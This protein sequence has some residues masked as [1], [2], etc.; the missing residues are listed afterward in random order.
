MIRQH[1][2]QFLSNRINV[3]AFSQH[4]YQQRLGAKIFN[5]KALFPFPSL[6]ISIHCSFGDQQIKPSLSKFSII[7][8]FFSYQY[9]RQ[10]LSQLS[11]HLTAVFKF[12]FI[13]FYIIYVIRLFLYT[14]HHFISSGNLT[15]NFEDICL[16]VQN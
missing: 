3:Y 12:Y 8:T 6:H 5:G 7:Q 2:I 9:V 14:L 10:V 4:Q 16:L 1:Q 11:R 13:K 15:K